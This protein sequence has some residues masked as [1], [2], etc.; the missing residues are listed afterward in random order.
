MIE[1]IPAVGGFLASVTNRVLDMR[2]A[3]ADRAHE[4]EMARDKRE[5]AK[6]M[7]SQELDMASW[8]GLDKSMQHDASLKG[9]SPIVQNIR[10]MVRPAL[11]VGALLGAGF[12]IEALEPLANLTVAWW[13]GDRALGMKK[14]EG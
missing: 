7:H 8:N 6:L 13:F 2:Q 1:L 4:L 10:A 9:V 11:T 3:K 5:T 12:G 14:N